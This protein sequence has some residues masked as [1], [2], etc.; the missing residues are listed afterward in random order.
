[1]TAEPSRRRALLTAV[2]VALGIAALVAAFAV[3]PVQRWA[4]TLGTTLQM[5]GPAGALA[6]W[7]CYVVAAMALVPASALSLAAGLIFGPWGI[8][9]AWLAMMAAAALAYP[10]AR[11]FVAERVRRLLA[12]RRDLRAV[13]EVIDEEGWRAVLLVRVSGIVPFG[14]QNYVLGATRIGFRPYLAATAIGILPSILVYAGAGALAPAAFEPGS[15]QPIR[16]VGLAVAA[17]AGLVLVAVT[18]RKVRAR[19]R[20]RQGLDQART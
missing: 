2:G 10:L 17:L 19:L 9:L 14:V 12:T 15:G 5:L 4:V 16:F 8:A 1:M 18:L 20:D 13:A 11:R 6:F 7:A 3:L